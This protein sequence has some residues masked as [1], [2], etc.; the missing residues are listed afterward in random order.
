MR[1]SLI[2]A[3]MAA[4][5][6][7]IFA[8]TGIFNIRFQQG[9]NISTIADTGTANMQADAMGA[10]VNG[11]LTLQYRGTQ[12]N[13]II[14]TVDVIGSQDFT[15]SSDA[16]VTLSLNA[17]TQ[18]PVKFTPSTSARTNAR[19]VIGYQEGR[20][21]SSVTI[22]LVGVTPEF[23]FS[24]TPPQ[25]NATPLSDG[26]NI[27]FP[28][29]AIDQTVSA[30]VVALNRGSGPGVVKS[31]SGADVNPA[32]QLVN[33]PLPNVGVDP[34]QSLRFNINFTPKVVDRVTGR[35]SVELFNSK[36]S[37]GFEGSGTRDQY[38]YEVI[39]EGGPGQLAPDGLI[40]LPDALVGEKSQVT[41]RFRNTGN[42]DGRVAAINI[43]GAAFS[44]LESPFTPLT[45]APGAGASLT[46][47]FTP[48]ESGR[49]VGRLRIGNDSFDIAGNGLAP[50]L[51]YSFSAA[52][53]TTQT[54][55]SGSVIFAP[56]TV[57]ATGRLTFEVSN[58]GTAPTTLNSVSLASVTA[59]FDLEGLP[60]LPLQLNAG[61]SARFTVAFAP[62]TVG[63]ATTTLRVDTA[64]F[65]LNATGTQP[66]PLPGYRFDGSTGNVG[67]VEQP[68]VGL[69][70]AQAYPLALNGVLTLAFNS[71]VFSNDP[72]VQFA[73][74]GRTINFTIPA[75]GTRAVFANGAQQIRLQTGTVS[76]NMTLTPSFTTD[77]GINLT[78][79][80]PDSL[81][82]T[83]PASAP[84][85]L[86]AGLQTKGTNT[87]TLLLT[88]YATTRS[89]TTIDLRITPVSGENV[90]TSQ[91]TLNVESSFIAWYQ[92]TASQ[93]F[94]SL[95]T[96][97]IPLTL[98]GDVN[99]A[100]S[101]ADTVQS[102]A[103]TIA[104]RNGTSQSR[105]IP[106]KQ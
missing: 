70:L 87:L 84:V 71:D 62:T 21:I 63:A 16:P 61:Q 104:N 4:L 102:I 42:V 81:T 40:S 48:R 49:A 95:F 30:S 32:F 64:T 23:V 59:G 28:Q 91:L 103:V 14:N 58:T 46:I 53:V 15:V 31:I 47:Q 22:N 17:T 41:V 77:G 54:Q 6:S 44:L 5:T 80:R 7:P 50:V 106:V 1:P 36:I 34:G 69:T 94:G 33:L 25:G 52:G 43:A 38:T 79:T 8:Q 29:T 93:A 74:G 86:S 73:T 98:A 101:L 2:V 13:V 90:S 20:T 35:A 12:A 24:Y 55:N 89:I 65:T 60:Q 67:P 92:S 97:T 3:A 78:P 9:Q 19:L 83:L 99:T 96:V 75:N 100:T 27:V 37:F 26:A 56:V 66:P 51:S 72:S 105:T 88:G 76:G 82:L 39:R 18:I 68:A 57:G 45:L 85:L 10:P 11:L